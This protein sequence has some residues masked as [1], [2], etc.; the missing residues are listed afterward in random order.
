MMATMP[1][2]WTSA[3]LIRGN[4]CL[5][6]KPF[7]DANVLQART[8]NL[9]RC[10]AGVRIWEADVQTKHEDRIAGKRQDTK[11]VISILLTAQ[12]DIPVSAQLHADT[13]DSCVLQAATATAY[14]C[15][16]NRKA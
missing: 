6:S 5:R 11:I 4:G 7:K 13:F 12:E 8:G 2:Y 9:S 14:A 10:E 3:F 15:M 1:L 16:R